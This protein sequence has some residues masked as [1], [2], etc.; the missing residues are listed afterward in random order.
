MG[1]LHTQDIERLYRTE[2]AAIWRAVLVYSGGREDMAD[3]AV[4]E[5]FAAALHGSWEIRS[6]RAWLFRV[7]LRH[8]GAALEAERK[9]AR[10]AGRPAESAVTPAMAPE[11]QSAVDLLS[12]LPPSQ[13]AVIFLHY[14]LDMSVRD[15]AQSLGTRPVAVRVQLHRAR[16]RLRA[17]LEGEDAQVREGDMMSSDLPRA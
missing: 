5:A 14:Y 10:T 15:I 8:A 17:I 9:R 2:S 7:A 1:Q 4:A 13:R 11:A 16:Q 6:P 3:D 12:S